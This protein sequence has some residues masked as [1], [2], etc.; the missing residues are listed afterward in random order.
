MVWFPTSSQLSRLLHHENNDGQRL[1]A[2]VANHE[3]SLAAAHGILIE[4]E[5]EAHN[6][7]SY[8]VGSHNVCTKA[9]GTFYAAFLAMGLLV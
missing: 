5:A 4:M 9:E 3:G 1:L 2:Y 8:S 7:D 6:H